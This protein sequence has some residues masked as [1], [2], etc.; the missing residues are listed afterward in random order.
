M[1]GLQQMTAGTASLLLNLE[2]VFTATLAWWVFKEHTDK[3]II[4]GMILIVLGG[5]ILV[6]PADNQLQLSVDLGP[7]SV[8][9]ACFCWAVDNNLTRKVSASDALFIAGSKGLIAGTVNTSLAWYL[10][11]QLPT[12]LTLL[13]SL[14]LGFLGYGVSLVFFVLALRSLGAGR[15]GA[16]FSTAPFLGAVIA[17]LVL[18]ESVSAPFCWAALL[19][20]VGVVLHLAE[21]HQHIHTHIEMEHVHRHTH[22]EH[23]QHTHDFVWDKAKNEAHSHTHKHV[24]LIHQHIHFP[25]IHHRHTHMHTVDQEPPNSDQT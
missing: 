20:G 15:T 14:S 9:L 8:V 22:D 24:E 6:W 10:G 7:L 23:H 21:R 17:I 13:A 5:L 4:L 19:M 11:A 2:A 12:G 25:D 1:Y 18:H 16:Y 3:R